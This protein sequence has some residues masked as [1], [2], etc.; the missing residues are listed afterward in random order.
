MKCKN[1]NHF[2]VVKTKKV[3]YNVVLRGYLNK[4]FPNNVKIYLYHFDIKIDNFNVEIKKMNDY[5]FYYNVCVEC[6]TI[7]N[8]YIEKYESK[9]PIKCEQKLIDEYFNY[10]VNNE[11]EFKKN[12][13]LANKIC[14]LE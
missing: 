8:L 3:A 5:Y 13:I 12:L 9:F 4:K 7:L 2:N 14:G 10:L 1:N 6:C 11:I